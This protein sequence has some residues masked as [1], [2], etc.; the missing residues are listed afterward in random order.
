MYCYLLT[1]IRCIIVIYIV[2]IRISLSGGGWIH[3]NASIREKIR[4][5]FF[6][7]FQ[8]HDCEQTLLFFLFRS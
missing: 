7:N 4:E 3:R 1:R 6:I 2:I 8:F 5:N